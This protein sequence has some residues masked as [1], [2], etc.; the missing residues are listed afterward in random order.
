MISKLPEKSEQGDCEAREEV[1][2]GSGVADLSPERLAS[3][4][5][6]GQGTE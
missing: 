1:S 6:G 5:A 3:P 2:L 4:G